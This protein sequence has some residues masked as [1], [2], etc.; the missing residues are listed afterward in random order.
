MAAAAMGCRRAEPDDRAGPAAAIP[1]PVVTR[2]ALDP[3]LVAG[4][5]AGVNFVEQEAE[6]ASTCDD[7]PPVVPP[8]PPAQ[9]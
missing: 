3:S 8:P 4:R 9:W 5:G 6:T 1:A 7:R 2:A